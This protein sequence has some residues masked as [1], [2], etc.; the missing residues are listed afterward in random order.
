MLRRVQV[1]QVVA[2]MEETLGLP[3]LLTEVVVV[4]VVDQ[5]GEAMAVMVAQVL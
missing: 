2:V 1:A 4:V 5:V 3:V